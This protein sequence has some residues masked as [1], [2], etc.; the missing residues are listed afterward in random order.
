[1]YQTF[2][3]QELQ[4]TVLFQSEHIDFRLGLAL[5]KQKQHHSSSS[6]SSRLNGSHTDDSL[7]KNFAK[8]VTMPCRNP[9]RDLTSV[10]VGISR[11]ARTL[12]G[13]VTTPRDVS[14]WPLRMAKVYPLRIKCQI[15]HNTS[16]LK[17]C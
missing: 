13:S 16:L 17:S 8:Y 3:R 4:T 6:S 10:G 9:F 2:D 7:G 15:E 1:M 5:L 11:M 14:K 12:L